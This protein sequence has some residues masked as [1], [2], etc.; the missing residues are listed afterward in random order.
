[1]MARMIL[2]LGGARS[3]KSEFALKLAQTAQ[4]VVFV[5]TGKPVDEEM[6]KRIEEHRRRRPAHWQTIEVEDNL[7]EII[8]KFG[9]KTEVLIV[10]CLTIYVAT[11][12]DKLVKEE[13]IIKHFEKIIQISQS[14][15]TNL[16]FISNEVGMGVI[17][18]FKL[19][20]LYRD[21][22]GKVNQLVAEASAEVYLMVAGLPV[23]LKQAGQ[24]STFGK[25][26]VK[27]G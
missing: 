25:S 22:L 26:S 3:G 10:D 17:P 19:G 23:S 9:T 27:Q 16:V 20:R 2:V 11:L 12:L 21:V 24:G 13:R 18:P 15:K 4:N 14:S 5:A 7:P 6:A 1:M 8:T